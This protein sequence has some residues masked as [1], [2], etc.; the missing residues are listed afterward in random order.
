M[1]LAIEIKNVTRVLLADGWHD[2]E[3]DSFTVDSYEYIQSHPN[4]DRNPLVL[5]GGG[6]SGVCAAG[7]AFRGAVGGEWIAGPLTAILAVE[8]DV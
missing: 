6:N 4:P 2:V 1:S 8:E 3:K 7:F 5:H